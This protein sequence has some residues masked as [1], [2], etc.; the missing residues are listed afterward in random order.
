MPP[1]SNRILGKVGLEIIA[2]VL[3][4]VTFLILHKHPPHIRGFYCDDETLLH[5]YTEE[6]VF[7][8]WL[9]GLVWLVIVT[10]IL[11][12]IELFRN[13]VMPRPKK[14]KLIGQAG[15]PWFVAD[16]Y[17]IFGHFA[18]GGLIT[19]IITETAKISI[20]R[21]RPHFLDLCKV[22]GT[23]CKEHPDK[24]WAATK[25]DDG[26]VDLSGICLGNGAFTGDELDQKYHEAR[27]SFMS[28]HTSTAFYAA[29]FLIVYL[30][31]RI[32]GLPLNK[33]ETVRQIIKAFRPLIQVT[34]E[35]VPHHYSRWPPSPWPAGFPSQE[36][37]T[38]SIT[39]L[40]SPLGL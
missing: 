17:R 27:L 29:I 25:D 6:P 26:K 20:G 16:F 39:R 23:S 21:L 38:T 15:L 31:Y 37:A 30:Q 24:F 12:P 8:E 34:F 2:T 35:A 1:S 7:P 3:L 28:G 11:L 14:L 9:A 33:M 40:I 10:I 4:G 22:N 36:S 13:S 19:L 18:Q 32:E 5:P